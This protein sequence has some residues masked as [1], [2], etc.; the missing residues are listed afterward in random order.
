M[1]YYIHGSGNPEASILF[2]GERPGK[3]E[4]FKG[5]PFVG[6]SGVEFNRYLWK[7]C[8]IDREQVFVTNMARDYKDKN[9]DPEPWELRRDEPML[10]K[11]INALPNLEVIVTLGRFSSRYFIANDV[12][13]D[14]AHG[15]VHYSDRY[16]CAVVPV[17][18]PAAGL[19]NTEFQAKIWW[20]FEQLHKFLTGH[21]DTLYAQSDAI[22]S[23]I[24]S[25]AWPNDDTVRLDKIA[26][27]TEGS[28][29]H[30][31]CLSWC[32]R[33]GKAHVVTREHVRPEM[34]DGIY[35]WLFHNALHDLAV[36]RSMGIEVKDGTYDDTMV[37]AYEL[38]VEPQGLKSLGWRHHGMD[39]MEYSEITREAS[40]R[41][42]R[43]YVGKVIE[44]LNRDIKDPSSPDTTQGG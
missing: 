21:P 19:H 32:D 35:K 20:D 5:K 1:T 22:P 9:P 14:S 12:D 43:E 4:Y 29:A 41:H 28:I 30:P 40:E 26:V 13:M 11:E 39:M 36:L 25:R 8:R 38:G 3:E 7:S 24:Y 15:V 44:W 27:D 17:F 31:W 6:K 37:M 2:V 33:P 42:A 16:N 23:P 34:Y 18:H 10:I